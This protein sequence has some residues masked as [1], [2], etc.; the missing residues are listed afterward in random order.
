MKG[1]SL[2]MKEQLPTNA[3]HITHLPM[4]LTAIS[5]NHPAGWDELVVSKSPM[6]RPTDTQ[7]TPV[8][9]HIR[10]YCAVLDEKYVMDDPGMQF[11]KNQ[12][13]AYRLYCGCPEEEHYCKKDDNR[14]EKMFSF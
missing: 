11:G 2:R 3:R 6:I 5:A 12:F 8:A 14:I 7:M 9:D 1:C 10:E 13:F 4:Y